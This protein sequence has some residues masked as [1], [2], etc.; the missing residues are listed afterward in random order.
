MKPNWQPAISEAWPGSRYESCS[1]DGTKDT[2][3]KKDR[4]SD[5]QQVYGIHS[6]LSFCS[7]V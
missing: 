4:R 5:H 1:R 7:Y 2:F 6:K 3:L